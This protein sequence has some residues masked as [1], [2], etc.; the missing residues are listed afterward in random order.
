MEDH[1]ADRAKICPQCDLVYY[2][3]LAPSIIVLVTRGDEM[4]LARNANWPV[5]MFSTLAGFVEPGESIE[6]TVHREVMEE[7]GLSV[8]RLCAIWA[9]RAGHSQIP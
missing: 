2:P 9:V 4:L 1:G 8:H 5:N 7:V 3:R 6:Q